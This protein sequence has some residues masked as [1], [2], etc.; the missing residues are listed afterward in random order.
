MFSKACST[1]DGAGAAVLA[2]GDTL[3]EVY[4]LLQFSQTFVLRSG[5]G[6][7]LSQ[8]FSNPHTPQDSTRDTC[9][10]LKLHLTCVAR[11]SYSVYI[12][13]CVRDT[14]STS[15]RISAQTAVTEISPY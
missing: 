14:V 8:R 12:Y 6:S 2:Q 3:Q 4:T 15:C 1:D 5:S 11:L 10:Q 7:H 13:I 9:I